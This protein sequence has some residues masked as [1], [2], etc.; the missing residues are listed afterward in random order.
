MLDARGA[1]AHP[2]G[3]VPE[4]EPSRTCIIYFNMY[5]LLK[6]VSLGLHQKWFTSTFDQILAVSDCSHKL[7]W[8]ICNNNKLYNNKLCWEYF[9]ISYRFQ[10]YTLGKFQPCSMLYMVFI[11]IA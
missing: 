10:A 9:M 6:A 7:I 4:E 2:P 8:D 3:F 11:V 5:E 1:T